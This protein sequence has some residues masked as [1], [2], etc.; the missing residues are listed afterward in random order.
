MGLTDKKRIFFRIRKTCSIIVKRHA[1]LDYPER[2]F[3]QLEI[4]NIIRNNNGQIAKND[5]PS[6]KE[7]SVLFVTS[8]DDGNKC[9]LVLF[10][11]EEM[12]CLT[13]SKKMIIAISAY[14]KL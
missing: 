10:V 8:D 11:E 7:G 3:T 4:I 1:Y 2:K 5:Y 6:A 14:R 9:E 12:D 13:K